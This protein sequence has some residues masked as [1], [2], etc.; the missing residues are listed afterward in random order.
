MASMSRGF[1]ITNG[2]TY[3]MHTNSTD[4]NIIDRSGTSF[5]G[6][7]REVVEDFADK[8]AIPDNPDRVEDQFV[9]QQWREIEETMVERA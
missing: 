9:L 2:F 8:V 4:V 7:V 6:Y 5:P 3:S 1:E